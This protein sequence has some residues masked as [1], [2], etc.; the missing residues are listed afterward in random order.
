MWAS[1]EKW[2]Y[3]QW[4]DPILAQTPAMT[5]GFSN[6]LFMD[7]AGV[8]EFTLAFGLLWTSLVRRYSA[9]VLL[10]VFVS[11]VFSFGKL[12]A[13]G[14]API[15]VVLL[16]FVSD[17]HVMDVRRLPWRHLRRAV[18]PFERTRYLGAATPAVYL[19]VL[20]LFLAAYYGSHDALY[21]DPVDP[22]V[23][24]A[25]RNGGGALSPAGYADAT[26]LR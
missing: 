1:V 2:A 9:A 17:D 21:P 7:A 24:A 26:P 5:F 13:I 10:V 23:A 19:A 15:I 8:I 14:H 25:P 4:T 3:P 20:G 18:A 12:D 16:A 22:P 6:A 11:A